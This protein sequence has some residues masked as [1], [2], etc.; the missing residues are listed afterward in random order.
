MKTIVISLLAAACLAS[1]A[2]GQDIDIRDYLLMGRFS[3]WRF[4]QVDDPDDIRN[5]AVVGF[6]VVGDEV[7]YTVRLPDVGG[8]QALFITFSRNTAGEMVMHALRIQDEELED[9][10]SSAPMVFNPPVVIGDASTPLDG[11]P[12]ITP[13]D[14][15]FNVKLKVGPI[16]ETVTVFVTGTIAISLESGAAVPTLLDAP[17]DLIEAE[18]VAILRITP[19]LLLVVDED[20]IDEEGTVDD[21]VVL[22]L[23]LDRGVVYMEEAGDFQFSARRL[24]KAI[25]PGRTLGEFPDN[26]DITSFS[27]DVPGE[28]I[29]LNGGA[30][31]TATGGDAL[32]GDGNP[33]GTLNLTEV[34]LEQKLNGALTL[35]GKASF[36]GPDPGTPTEIDVT[37][38]GKAVFSAKTGLT[39]LTLA[40]TTNKGANKL[41][42]LEKPIVI[43]AKAEL[44]GA[45]DSLTL[46][47]KS[48]KDA[49]GTL[50]L[51]LSPGNSPTAD[52]DLDGL[53]D[54]L[55][56]SPKARPLGSEGFLTFGGADFPITL[57]E[58][59]TSPKQPEVGDPLPD[60][61][62]YTLRH[63]GVSTVIGTLKALSTED[64]MEVTLFKAKLFGAPIVLADP[65]NDLDYATDFP[66]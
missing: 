41:D 57:T 66:E 42:I 44:T 55:F 64:G 45:S 18:E 59:R 19:N 11:P 35:T 12:T 13:V 38:K 21:E 1:N 15:Q 3:K 22:H 62:S 7:R 34:Q 9:F 40:G 49:V 4:E 47:F 36:T 28:V 56:E 8:L 65:D 53:V 37:L 14:T 20:G 50:E 23:A 43:K 63:T 32:D 25:L 5:V 33:A 54:V 2:V 61:R 52:V 6:Q 16:S 24:A 48:G 26:N 58:T 17:D 31:A 46:N 51:G 29:T 39:K 10:G 27:F 30:D 60:K